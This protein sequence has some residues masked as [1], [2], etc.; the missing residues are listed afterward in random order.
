MCFCKWA[1]RYSLLNW[2]AND[3]YSVN[4]GIGRM[5]FAQSLGLFS[6]LT[7]GGMYI[8]YSVMIPIAELFKIEEACVYI[9]LAIII[10]GHIV[11]FSGFIAICIKRMQDLG[12]N[13]FWKILNSFIMFYLI[14]FGETCALK[15]SVEMD[16][17]TLFLLLLVVVLFFCKGDTTQHKEAEK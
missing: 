14:M 15:G 16:D 12:Q 5:K 6:I 17:S 8:I 3:V 11:F 2:M 9:L 1:K 7:L 4:T 13:W 10:L